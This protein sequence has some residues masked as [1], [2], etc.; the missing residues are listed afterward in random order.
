[1]QQF[2]EM[3]I[4]GNTVLYHKIKAEQ[5]LDRPPFPKDVIFMSSAV[6]SFF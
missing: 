1:M 5:L 6:E 2:I 3:C 4:Y